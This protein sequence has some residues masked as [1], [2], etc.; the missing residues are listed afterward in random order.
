METYNSK[1]PLASN[2]LL[3]LIMYLFAYFSGLFTILVNYSVITVFSIESNLQ[4]HQKTYNL[5]NLRLNKALFLSFS[6]NILCHFFV[7]PDL[8]TLILWCFR[9]F[10]RSNSYKTYAVKQIQK[11]NEHA[12]K[13]TY[14]AQ[15]NK[16]LKYKSGEFLRIYDNK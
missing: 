6:L 3:L 15:S 14:P 5:C 2:Q 9:A 11:Q 7:S 10:W 1:P 12:G 4:A 16:M 8:Y 13:L